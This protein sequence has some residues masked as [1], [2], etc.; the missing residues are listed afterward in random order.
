MRVPRVYLDLPLKQGARIELDDNA[1]NHCVKVLRLGEGAL[2]T[3]FN[4]DGLEYPAELCDV[5]K[6]S[7]AAQIGAPEDQG[8]E[9][10]LTIQVGQAISRGE[11][12]DYAIQKSSELGIARI[13]PLFTERCEVRLNNERQEKR[14]RHWQQVAISACEQ[15]QRCKVP[16]IEE[17][18]SLTDWLGQVN[19]E[20][21]LVMHHH[22]AKPLASIAPPASVALLVG[23]EGGLTEEEVEQAIAAGFQP[24]AFGPRVMRTE[25]APVAAAAILQYLWGDLG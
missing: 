10:P 18:C 8:R 3:L 21:K 9:S 17:P 12:M 5:A 7:A 24:V 19:A 4:G 2:L 11:R 20:L 14:Q 23:P 15:S 1:F 16:V 13:S 22:T 6:K 25:T